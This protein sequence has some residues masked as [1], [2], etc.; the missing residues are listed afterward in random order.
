MS[1]FSFET[2]KKLQTLS[3][4]TNWQFGTN[5]SF[6][7]SWPSGEKTRV[8]DDVCSR[9]GD[10]VAATKIREETIFCL[11]ASVQHFGIVDA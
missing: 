5:A 1:T 9:F 11:P 8:N 3:G 2:L 7:F 4:V 10:K 6:F